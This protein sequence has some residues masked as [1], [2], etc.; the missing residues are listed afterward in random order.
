MNPP[1]TRYAKSDKV[2]IAYSVFGEGPLD[3]VLVPGFISHLELFWDNP[4]YVHAMERLATFARVINFDKRGTGLSDAVS[5][6]PTLEV[7]MDDVRAVM[8]AAGS[9]RAAIWGFSEGAAMTILFA[10]THPERTTALVL[11]GA[12]AKGVA[13]DDYPWGPARDVFDEEGL[14]MLASQWGEGTSIEVFS[15]SHADDPQ[16]REFMARFERMS[17]S[18]GAL[19][20]IYKMFA[21][22][23]VRHVLPSIK[24]PTL[25]V[26]RKGD[27]AV[28]VR[29]SRWMA[30]QIPGAKY[31]EFEGI[32][33]GLWDEYADPILDEVEEFLTGVRPMP[34]P[35][36][37]LATVMFT[38]VVEST[39]RAAELG[40]R[41]WVELLEAHEKVTRRE[42]DRFRGREV[43][44]TGDGFL[45]TFDGPA[46]AI[47]C[48]KA[49]CDGVRPLGVEV[50]AGLHT[51]ECE[52]LGAD[53]GGIAVHIAA[54]VGAM[55]GAGE[56]L[57]S[58][59]VRDL[60]AGSGIE[61]ADRG[62]HQLKGVPDSWHIFAVN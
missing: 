17:A 32:N 18:P 26:H 33:H 43:K 42:L 13:S 34:E 61:F 48:A 22:I 46:R 52:A 1:K 60:V 28:N 40:D 7:R 36:R 55:A 44:T 47:R 38:D 4:A 56:V 19:V 21:D 27:R 23:D 3:L 6:P 5:D 57:V 62:E 49:I 30:E 15:A 50:R 59:T 39:K 8:D 16:A 25:L 29:N 37:I 14:E 41:R 24:V 11:Y 58:R 54:R 12:L 2:N 31:T 10:A 45:A 35:D 20:A 51:G 9:E 53:I